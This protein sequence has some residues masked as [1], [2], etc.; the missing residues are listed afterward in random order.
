[1]MQQFSIVFSW[2]WHDEL[3]KETLFS[4]IPKQMLLKSP[5]PEF[6]FIFEIAYFSL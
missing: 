3:S 4:H 2:Y 1:M 5:L 6:F